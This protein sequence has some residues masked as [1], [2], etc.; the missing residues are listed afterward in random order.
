MYKDVDF[1]DNGFVFK[2]PKPVAMKLK[3]VIVEDAAFLKEAGLMDYSLL[4]GIHYRDG[5]EKNIE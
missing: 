4:V 3:S 2:L 1:V 5:K